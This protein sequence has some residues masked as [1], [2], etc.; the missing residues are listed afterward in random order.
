MVRVLAPYE[1][2]TVVLPGVTG[3]VAKFGGRILGRIAS[4]LGRRG[5]RWYLKPKTP[6]A[7]GAVRRG[8]AGGLLY[9]LFDDDGG[10][11]PGA[12][13]PTIPGPGPYKQR[14]SGFR[15][16]RG[17]SRRCNHNYNCNCGKRLRR[18]RRYST[19]RG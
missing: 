15:S 14:G 3:G 1:S 10:L 4:Q 5:V 6:T 8:I 17:S 9:E 7:I 13:P 12:V 11:S 2:P 19:Y 18:Y 16:F